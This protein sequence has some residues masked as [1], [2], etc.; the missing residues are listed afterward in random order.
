MFLTPINNFTKESL[1]IYVRILIRTFI[2][3]CIFVKICLQDFILSIFV[4]S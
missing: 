3:I 2:Q 1:S 4:D